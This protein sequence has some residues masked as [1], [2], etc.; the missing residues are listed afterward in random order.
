[1]R[2]FF[3]GWRRKAGT[4]T[5]VLALAVAGIWMRSRIVCDTL[6]FKF[7]GRL[8][9]IVS[10]SNQTSG[11]SWKYELEFPEV[12]DWGSVPLKE[13]DVDDIEGTLAN[14][15]EA[16]RDLGFSE[17]HIP[18]WSLVLPLTLLSAYLILGKPRKR[19]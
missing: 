14:Y 3:Q 18:Y 13:V 17:W 4:V 9:D 15:R 8:H 1:M 7:R 16:Y 10:Y 19:N 12:M 2:E 6:Q 11:V 5:L